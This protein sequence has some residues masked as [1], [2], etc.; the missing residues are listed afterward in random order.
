MLLSDDD[1][2]V[3]SN[4]AISAAYQAGQIITQHTGLQ[5]PVQSKVAGES[6]ASQVVTEVDMLC[7]ESILKILLPSCKLFDLAL[8]TEESADDNMRLEK[9]HFWC[10]DPLDGTLP[11]IEKS[12]GYAVS[13]ALVS[14]AGTALIGVIYDPVR[15]TLYHAVKGTGAFLNNKPWTIKDI[16]SKESHVLTIVSDRSFS[17]QSNYPE[18][19]KKL[20]AAAIELGFS[21]I[22]KIQHGGAAMN[23]CWTL[24]N[25]PGCYF[26]FPK[27]QNGGGS[28]WD[29]AATSCLFNEIGA[30][31]SNI[32]GNPL[33][34]NRPDS[35]FMNHQG[36][37][38]ASNQDIAE[39]IRQI[40]S[41]MPPVFKKD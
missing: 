39:K 14:H 3:L 16:S 20:E 6:L 2:I 9:D 41:T 21:G 22:K 34:L 27:Q 23:A 13:I 40:Y 1:L 5:I 15:Q 38:Y 28:L 8:L 11:F 24:E 35:T 37:I 12:S 36:I 33:D 31:V 26:K 25:N 32:D 29:Y 30:V 18:I 7:Q 19:I 17:Q 4:K 10:I